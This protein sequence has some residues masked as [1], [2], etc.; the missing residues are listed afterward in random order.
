[1]LQIIGANVSQDLRLG[2]FI[3]EGASLSG[4]KR[5]YF[6]R[7]SEGPCLRR[8]GKNNSISVFFR[9]MASEKVSNRSKNGLLGASDDAFE[10]GACQEKVVPFIFCSISADKGPHRKIPF[11]F[12]LSDAP[13]APASDPDSVVPR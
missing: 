6:V 2:S 10:V 3:F 7:A 12:P 11:I 9:L 13:P 4:K 8:W 5:N 1:M